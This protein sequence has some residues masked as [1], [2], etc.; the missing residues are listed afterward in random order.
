[1]PCYP[2]ERLEKFVLSIVL[3]PILL[4]ALVVCGLALIVCTGVVLSLPVIALIHPESIT[5]K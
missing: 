2:K 5:I 1:M 4:V 3:V